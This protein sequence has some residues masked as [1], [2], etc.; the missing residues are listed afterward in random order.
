VLDA[1][2]P[3]PSAWRLV[4]VALACTLVAMVGGCGGSSKNTTAPAVGT[5]E[6]L[7]ALI[8]SL[9]P[10]E[11][12]L[13]SNVESGSSLLATMDVESKIQAF[14]ALRNGNNFVNGGDVFSS[15][16]GPSDPPETVE[17]G[18]DVRSTPVNS[19]EQFVYS[20][21]PSHPAGL[22][23]AFDG[24]T[25]HRFRVTG[26]AAYP[27]RID[28]VLSVTPVNPAEPTSGAAVPR[29]SDLVVTWR[30]GGTDTTVYVGAMVY[31]TADPT[32]RRLSG[33]VR[34]S[35]GQLT[36]KS[37]ALMALPA[38]ATTLAVVRFRL[39]YV[40]AGVSR[41]G[42]LVEAGDARPIDLQ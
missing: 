15:G 34:D 39:R 37:A 10:P 12:V 16:R 40:G 30:D 1:A 28:S 13:P 9:V 21:L 35:D 33:V 8:V 31:R 38:G 32:Q 7:V 18:L 23:L 25:P 11:F 27:A 2:R 41:T 26:S 17:V 5:T 29:A 4:R 20:T 24:T 6:D 42:L 22:V 19:V 3:C 36:L 14:A